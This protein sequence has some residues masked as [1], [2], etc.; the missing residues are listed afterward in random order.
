MSKLKNNNNISLLNDVYTKY[1]YGSKEFSIQVENYIKYLITRYFSDY[2]SYCELEDLIQ[3]CYIKIHKILNNKDGYFDPSKG[4]LATF[5]FTALRNTVGYHRRKCLELPL[6]VDYDFNNVEDI[7]SFNPKEDSK[8]IQDTLNST[9]SFILSDNLIN[10]L[11]EKNIYI[12]AIDRFLSW[13][14]IQSLEN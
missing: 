12:P 11:T 5:I 2:R 7:E 10:K 8:F 6:V 9:Q 13:K 1:G 4:T 3:E 14:K